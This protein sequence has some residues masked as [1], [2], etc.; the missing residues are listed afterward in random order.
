MTSQST[1]CALSIVA[2]GWLALN[3]AACA[4]TITF[5][6]KLDAASEVPASA[7]TGSGSVAAS[8]DTG[9]KTLAWTGSFS[10]LTGDATAAHFHGPAV[11]GAN[12]AVAVPIA[13]FK[14][15]F[16]GTAP[17]TDAQVADLF[18]GKWYVNIHTAKFPNGE[19]RGQLVNDK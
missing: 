5:N 10:G 18:A 15:P 11:T 16:T 7:S 19:I 9:T 4:E 13:S 14:S 6:A 8:F 1:F 17:L 2:A 3:S 12:S